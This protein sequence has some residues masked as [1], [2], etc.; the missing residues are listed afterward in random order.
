[1]P[2]PTRLARLVAFPLALAAAL[3]VVSCHGGYHAMQAADSCRCTPSQYCHVR[4]GTAAECLPLPQACASS[5]SCSCLGRPVDACREELG[6]FTVLE[7]R[8]V[9]RCDE[10]SAEE[11]CWRQESRDNARSG[12]M[13]RLLPARCDDTPTCDCLM[14]THTPG[15]V[16]CEERQGRIEAGPVRTQ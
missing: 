11:Y 15:R 12:P 1:M 2:A 9:G 4:P 16:A 6:A 8:N 13:C 10:C 7:P 14:Q 3:A 5:P